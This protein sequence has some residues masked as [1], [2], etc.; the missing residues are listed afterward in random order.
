MAETITAS[1]AAGVIMLIIGALLG[2]LTINTKT[3]ED[4]EGMGRGLEETRKKLDE[5]IEKSEERNA[6]ILDS[7]LAI[8]LT[9][10][11]GSANGE[12]DGALKK[13]NDYNIKQGSRN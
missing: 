3:Q 1:V 10:K 6:L 2:R 4:V 12:I 5:H 8:M 11:K 7:L 9:L 13:L